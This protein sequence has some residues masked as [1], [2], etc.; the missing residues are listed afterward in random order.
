MQNLVGEENN[1]DEMEEACDNED[2]D[3]VF[4]PN[5]IPAELRPHN[6]GGIYWEA[7]STKRKSVQ[8]KKYGFDDELLEELNGYSFP[9]EETTVDNNRNRRT[10]ILPPVQANADKLALSDILIAVSKKREI[11]PGQKILLALA[12]C[13]EDEARLFEMFPEVLMFDVTH[14]T[15]NEKRPLG[16][17]A[18]IDQNF[19][20]CTPMRIFMP[21]ECQWTMSW[22]I[23]AALPN[24]LGKEP[25][26]RTQIFLC[27]G[28]SKIYRSYDQHKEEVMPNSEQICCCL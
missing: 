12:W 24:I 14:G 16:I 1:D 8:E 9:L 2:E 21:N 28:D 19:E 26:D 15:N 18:S 20:V 6:N 13:R 10:R 4:D 23:G 27:D 17:F 22:I 25:L 7:T 5:L 3:D 11:T